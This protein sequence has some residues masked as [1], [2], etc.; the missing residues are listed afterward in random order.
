RPKTVSRRTMPAATS[1]P[2]AVSIAS[3]LADVA[4]NRLSQYFIYL[5]FAPAVSS[6]SSN[7]KRVLASGLS[8]MRVFLV[9]MTFPPSGSQKIPCYAD[10]VQPPALHAR[11]RVGELLGSRP[12]R[13]DQ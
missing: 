13:S 2:S 6:S 11:K 1:S 8:K 10:A 3:E 12:K 4:R 5:R 7:S 9:F